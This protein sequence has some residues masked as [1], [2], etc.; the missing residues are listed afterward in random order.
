VSR[1]RAPRPA[2]RPL[3][4]S[5]HSVGVLSLLIGFLTGPIIW[6]MHEIASEILISSA[7]STSPGGFASTSTLGVSGWEIVLLLVTLLCG[8][9]VAGAGLIAFRA[10]RESRMGTN[11]TGDVGGAA[12]RSGWMALAGVL[13]SVFFLLGIVE[14]G[15]S[16][17]WLSGCH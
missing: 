16:I 17:F 4:R 15:L 13:F 7:C 2:A 3:A 8:A 6:S 11:E 14:A 9:L 12:G 5:K 10:W 1:G